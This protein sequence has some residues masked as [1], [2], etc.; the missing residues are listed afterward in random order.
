VW[1][2]CRRDYDRAIADFDAALK[3]DP[4]NLHAHLNRATARDC[5]KDYDGALAD[6]NE[7]LRLDPHSAVAY[8]NRGHAWYGKGE[9]EKAIADYD[10]AI[11]L[12]PKYAMAVKNRAMARIALGQ[13][14]K[15][16]SDCAELLR[17]EPNSA[18]S[19]NAV[20]WFLATCPDAKYRDGKRA[21]VLAKQACERTDWKDCGS[22][23]TLAAAHAE[24]GDFDEAVR[25]QQKALE[26]A[27]PGPKDEL[28]ARLALYKS[29]SPYHDR[30][31]AKRGRP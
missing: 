3:I 2:S 25:C 29:H 8:N 7:A 4:E 24:A 23:D 5:K 15:A 20:A 28:N 26:V 14:E 30:V 12:D 21:I 22:L 1:G 17:L 16:L 6:A 18:E 19:Y 31:K 11:Q 9:H 10:K 13:H 27:G